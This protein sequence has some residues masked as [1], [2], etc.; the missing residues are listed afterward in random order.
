VW[1]GLL[2]GMTKDADTRKL[3]EHLFGG[4]PCE[5]VVLEQDQ[6]PPKAPSVARGVFLGVRRINLAAVQK[7]RY[8]PTGAVFTPPPPGSKLRVHR[9][10]NFKVIDCL[11]VTLS[12]EYLAELPRQEIGI[13]SLPVVFIAI[14]DYLLRH[15]LGCQL[16]HAIFPLRQSGES[17]VEAEGE[18]RAA[19]QARIEEHLKRYNL[20]SMPK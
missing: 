14:N 5:F 4:A 12:W 1:K 18:V 3:I 17:I 16:Q 19:L 6:A 20:P 2:P 15:R 8:T 7:S 11:R 13:D 9:G 10:P